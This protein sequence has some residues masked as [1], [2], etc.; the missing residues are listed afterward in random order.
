MGRIRTSRRFTVSGRT[1][2]AERMLDAIEALGVSDEQVASRHQLICQPVD[3]VLLRLAIE[4]DHHVA[5]EDDREKP[6]V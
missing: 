6:D 5:A 1:D 2:I 4:V 3:K